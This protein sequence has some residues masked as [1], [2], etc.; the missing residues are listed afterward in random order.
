MISVR[1]SGRDKSNEARRCEIWSGRAVRAEDFVPPESM[2]KKFV[3][4]E[5][6]MQAYKAKKPELEKVIRE[7]IDL[8]DSI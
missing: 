5:N 8:L 2:K 1:P 7:A 6:T 3:E 4:Y